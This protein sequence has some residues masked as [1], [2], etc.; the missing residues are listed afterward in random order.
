M[1]KQLLTISNFIKLSKS[2]LVRKTQT[3]R[4]PFIETF[5][6]VDDKSRK[7]VIQKINR[8]SKKNNFSIILIK[9]K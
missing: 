4:N 2:V 8:L 1:V 5:E 7:E 3:L 9:E 6:I